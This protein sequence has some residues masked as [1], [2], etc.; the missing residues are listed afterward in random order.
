MTAVAGLLVLSTLALVVAC[1]R[2]GKDNS[3]VEGTQGRKLTLERPDDVEIERGETADITIKIKRE[4]VQDTV[5]VT[6]AGLPEGVSVINA[7]KSIVGDEAEF[8]LQADA[9]AALVENHQAKVTVKAVD[10]DI[11]TT[12]TFR[13]TVEENE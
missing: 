10:A 1:E 2:N 7:D 5:S 9:S 11:A 4:N 6:F 13:I 12:Q 8:R 3:T